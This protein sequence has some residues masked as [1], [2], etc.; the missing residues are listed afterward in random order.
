MGGERQSAGGGEGEVRRE[1]VGKEDNRR[2]KG[3]R[4]GGRSEVDVGEI[5][6]YERVGGRR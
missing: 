4:K 5:W 2:E 6:R 1:R 3:R